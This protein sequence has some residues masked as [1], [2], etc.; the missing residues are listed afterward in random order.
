LQA[1]FSFG[2]IARKKPRFLS[3]KEEIYEKVKKF[4]KRVF[5]KRV[6]CDKLIENKMGEGAKASKSGKIAP[7]KQDL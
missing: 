5:T 3:K 2:K 1:F 6:L 7:K 4:S